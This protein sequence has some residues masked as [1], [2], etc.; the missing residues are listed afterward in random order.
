MLNDVCLTEF[1]WPCLDYVMRRVGYGSARTRE[2]LEMDFSIWPIPD[3]LSEIPEGAIL[4]WENKEGEKAWQT[5]LKG[6][7]VLE[8]YTFNRGHYAVYEGDGFISDLGWQDDTPYIRFRKLADISK[9]DKMF[10]R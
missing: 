9:P 8:T 6:K 5:T 3:D 2:N 10:L 7:V 1:M 4:K